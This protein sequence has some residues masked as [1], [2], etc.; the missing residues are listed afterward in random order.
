MNIFK[1]KPLCGSVLICLFVLICPGLIT[2]ALAQ[3]SD[4]TVNTNITAWP[5]NPDDQTAKLMDSFTWTPEQENAAAYNFL[6]VAGQ[7]EA[8]WAAD[9][10]CFDTNDPTAP[11]IKLPSPPVDPATPIEQVTITVADSN[12]DDPVVVNEN[13]LDMVFSYTFQMDDPQ[14]GDGSPKLPSAVT[15]SKQVDLTNLTAEGDG[16]KQHNI[17]DGSTPIYGLDHLQGPAG[18]D[19]QRTTYI[20]TTGPGQDGAGALQSVQV[21]LSGDM[22]PPASIVIDTTGSAIPMFGAIDVAA[23]SQGNHHLLGGGPGGTLWYTVVDSTTGLASTPINMGTADWWG[24]PQVGVGPDDSLW[25][26]AYNGSGGWLSLWYKGPNGTV[27]TTRSITADPGDTVGWY[28]SMAVD[29]VT[30][31]AYWSYRHSSGRGKALMATSIWDVSWDWMSADMGN[32][33]ATAV[34][35]YGGQVNNWWATGTGDQVAV[36]QRS[37]NYGQ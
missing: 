20:Y 28:N 33:Y 5:G 29:P 32:P 30:G 24:W 11:A 16:W 22:S 25:A 12:S 15:V 35:A 26:S 6:A 7:S 1:W 19:G 37:C 23:D 10:Y 36:W 3:C 2:V 18:E 13:K 4:P 17:T 27:W 21:N 14:G 9:I 31:S 8:G 34:T